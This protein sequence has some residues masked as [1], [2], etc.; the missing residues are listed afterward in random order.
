M[1]K[2][3]EGTEKT[4]EEVKGKKEKKEKEEQEKYVY[5]KEKYIDES[6]GSGSER[7]FECELLGGIRF[8][9]GTVSYIGAVRGRGKTISLVKHSKRNNRSK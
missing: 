8:P 3:G 6:N 4:M 7:D 5:S 9:E 1:Q 2:M